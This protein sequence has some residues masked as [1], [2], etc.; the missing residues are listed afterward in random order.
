MNW[1]TSVFKYRSFRTFDHYNETFFLCNENIP[2]AV[3]LNSSQWSPIKVGHCISLSGISHLHFLRSSMPVIYAT[4][5]QKLKLRMQNVC[6]VGVYCKICKNSLHESW[7]AKNQICIFLSHHTA[8]FLGFQNKNILYFLL[9]CLR[10]LSL[11]LLVV[12]VFKCLKPDKA[13]VN[14]YSKLSGSSVC[15]VQ[16]MY[17]LTHIYVY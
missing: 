1:K 16:F 3:A 11:R 4:G 9:L 10:P 6:Y 12:T 7:H 17:R 8:A 14:F 15:I 5:S 2:Q 13:P